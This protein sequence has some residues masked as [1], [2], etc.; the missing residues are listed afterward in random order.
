MERADFTLENIVQKY[1]V[2]CAYKEKQKSPSGKFIPF[3][4]I[5]LTLYKRAANCT[6]FVTSRTRI[7]HW[8]TVIGQRLSAISDVV[9]EWKHDEPTK[10][11]FAV[12]DKRLG[13]EEDELDYRITVYLTTGKILI[14]GRRY[15]Q[16]CDREFGLC[17]DMVNNMASQ[18]APTQDSEPDNA[19]ANPNKQQKGDN[20]NDV[21]E[22]V[23]EETSAPPHHAEI[24]PLTEVTEVTGST[25]N[26]TPDNEPSES[27]AIETT[28]NGDGQQPDP[29]P[30]EGHVNDLN[31]RLDTM[32]AS[33]VNLTKAL[34]RVIGQQDRSDDNHSAVM[35]K[36]DKLLTNNR[37]VDKP[38]DKSPLEHHIKDLEKQ[39]NALQ[40]QIRELDQTNKN[41]TRKLKESYDKE[42]TKLKKDLTE[43]R[44]QKIRLEIENEKYREHITETEQNNNELK[45]SVE[46]RL[47]DKQ[48]I[49]DSLYDRLMHNVNADNG[50]PWE[51]VTRTRNTRPTAYNEAL[52]TAWVPRSD[53]LAATMATSTATHTDTTIDATVAASTITPG[54]TPM[55]TPPDTPIPASPGPRKQSSVSSAAES[56]MS[57]A[58]ITLLHD[59]VC[60]EIHMGRLTARGEGKGARLYAPTIRDASKAVDNLSNCEIVVLHTGV[61]DLKSKNVDQ[62]IDEYENLIHKII[63]K[64]VKRIITSLPT[65]STTKPWDKKNLKFQ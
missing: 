56:A 54:D 37:K 44:E 39:N 45:A 53:H 65:P 46:A 51:T 36:L 28:S 16:W 52:K 20:D 13:S 38:V 34:A 59:S 57:G 30:P 17:L 41:E 32:E 1:P 3:E 18:L 19:S 33:I 29:T 8:I 4:A 15:E 48:K 24:A 10:T 26:I 9:F 63:A 21:N 43:V 12:H 61:N 50:S 35:Q 64:P 31:N 25:E 58:S 27:D 7:H 23:H 5:D 62:V 55:T 6:S 49:I 22:T 42:I 60:K 47:S 2:N 14:Q 11:E 40:K